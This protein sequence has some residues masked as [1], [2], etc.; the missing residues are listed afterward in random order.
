MMVL[1]HE[2]RNRLEVEL[3]VGALHSELARLRLVLLLLHYALL[4]WPAE[5]LIAWYAL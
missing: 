4:E 2:E 3:V 1:E 5:S